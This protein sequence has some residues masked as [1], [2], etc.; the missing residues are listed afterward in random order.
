MNNLIQK[1]IE[2]LKENENKIIKKLNFLFNEDEKLFIN[3]KNNSSDEEENENNLNINKIN[4][5][6]IESE[7]KNDEF[8]FIKI[9]N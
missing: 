4:L 6:N 5:M 1:K 7:E 9:N 8:E 3:D 2:N